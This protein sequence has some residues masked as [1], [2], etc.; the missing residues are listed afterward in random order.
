M[1]NL[2]TLIQSPV[3]AAIY[4]WWKQRGDSQPSRPYLGGS[5][6]GHH[7]ERYLWYKFRRAVGGEIDGRLYRLFDRGH[8]E[9]HRFVEELRG[10]GC[11]V[12]EFGQDGQQIE[13]VS[14]DGHFKGHADGVAR[15]VPGAERTWHLLEFKTSNDKDFAA[16]IKDGVEQHK[17]QHYAQMQIYMHLLGLTRALY[18]VVN[19]NDDSLHAERIEY[20]AQAAKNLLSRAERIIKSPE[21]PPRPYERSDFYLCK[22]CSARDLCWNLATEAVPLATVDCRQC[23][24]STPINDGKWLCERR[25]QHGS[26]CDKHLLLPGFLEPFGDPVDATDESITYR[27]ADGYQFE[28]GCGP[29]RITS[30]DLASMPKDLLFCRPAEDAGGE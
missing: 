15:G 23:C 2:Q 8:K 9:E 1:S 11:E 27:A 22:W 7:C 17:A 10:I 25:Q 5:E 18:M 24:H 19:K 21:I 4:D 16:L 26:I 29:N 20:N 30:R 14:I 28:V 12:Y 13:V 6:I 3:V